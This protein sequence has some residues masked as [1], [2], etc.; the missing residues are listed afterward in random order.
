MTGERPEVSV[1]LTSYNH[2]RFVEQALDSVAAQTFR[3]FEL[4]ITDDCS[5]DASADRIRAWLERT[6]LGATLIVNGTNLG[7]TKVRNNALRIATGRFV[8]SL[9]GD[10]FYE[11]DRLAVQVRAFAS[12]EDDVGVV[13]GDLRLV[14]EDG[15]T[16]AA[17][18]L[19]GPWGA[20]PPPEGRVWSRLLA[21][22]FVPTPAVMVRR[23]ALDAVGP[24]DESLMAE[25]YDMWLRLADQFE[26][27]FVDAC[28]SNYRI[29][30]SSLSRDPG[31]QHERLDGNVRTLL[32]WRGRSAATDKILATHLW[33]MGWQ[34]ARVDRRH[35][36]SVMQTAAGIGVGR[37]RRWLTPLAR[38]PGLPRLV[39]AAY[40][41]RRG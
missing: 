5:T 34:M 12:C 8:C 29:L 17:S 7:I 28:V 38:V 11:P 25:D 1:L 37:A 22:D 23:A 14:D 4:I 27:R 18:H 13:Y 35:S 39:S 20:W 36:L 10:D 2:E 15:C 31:R 26:F 24:Y 16:I 30:P 41:R 33:D 3:D 9:A 6:G 32:K 40:R 19:R 21:H